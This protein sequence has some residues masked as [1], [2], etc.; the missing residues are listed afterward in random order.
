MLNDVKCGFLNRV[1]IVRCTVVC[2]WYRL[3]CRLTPPLC[4]N[5]LGLTHLD[6]HIT[7]DSDTVETA[8]TKV[9]TGINRF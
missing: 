2:L 3:L 6:S 4:L 7:K 1:Y 9:P 5:F 8:Y